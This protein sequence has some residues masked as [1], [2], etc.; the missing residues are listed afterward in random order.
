MEPDK[1]VLTSAPGAQRDML[2]SRLRELGFYTMLEVAS[3]VKELRAH[4][5]Q[6]T[7]EQDRAGFQRE[8]LETQI[9][10]EREI[11][12]NIA[13]AIIDRGLYD[14][15]P[16]YE[17]EGKSA[18]SELWTAARAADYKGVFFLQTAD[19]QKSPLRP[20]SESKAYDLGQRTLQL[21]TSEG[22]SPI[23]LP[24]HSL[25]DQVNLILGRLELDFFG[26]SHRTKF[27][28]GVR[29]KVGS[30]CLKHIDT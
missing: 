26:A 4:R 9:R 27:L 28:S 16:F 19:Y 1:Y 20:E 14:G 15:I 18:P 30:P 2:L 13:I 6:P 17:I 3:Y 10:W 7:A 24:S 29:D 11:P 5:K 22:H 8:V 23:V 12:R 25:D 21:Y